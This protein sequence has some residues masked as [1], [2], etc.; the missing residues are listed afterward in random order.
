MGAP[1]SV[2]GFRQ[3]V[4]ALHRKLQADLTEG[5]ADPAAEEERL[6]EQTLAGSRLAPIS[7]CVGWT[8]QLQSILA[9]PSQHQT[10]RRQNKNKKSVK[11]TRP[12]ILLMANPS[13]IENK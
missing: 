5:Q 13:R 9:E 1:T 3:S 12:R 2:N 6:F 11:K 7:F 10:K 4:L 8:F